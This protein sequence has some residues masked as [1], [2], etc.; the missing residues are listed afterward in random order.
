MFFSK[1][2]TEAVLEFETYLEVASEVDLR[3]WSSDSKI[4]EFLVIQ[5]EE[6]IKHMF[7]SLSRLGFGQK[8]AAPKTD[9]RFEIQEVKE[10]EAGLFEIQYKYKGTL[11]VQQYAHEEVPQEVSFVL[12]NDPAQIYGRGLVGDSNPCT[13]PHYQSERDFWYFWNPNQFSCPLIEGEDFHQVIGKIRRKQNTVATYPEYNRMMQNGVLPGFIIFG[14][15]HQDEIRDPYEASFSDPGEYLNAVN[16]VSLSDWMVEEGFLKE[17]ISFSQTLIGQDLPEY[18][19]LVTLEVFEKETP[20]GLLRFFLFYGP[21]GVNESQSPLFHVMFLTGLRHASFVIYN[22]HSGLG[23]NLNL[24]YFDQIYQ[25][26]QPAIDQYQ[27]YYFNSCSSYPYYNEM[28]F[29]RKST[30]KDPFG[31]KNLDI[32]TNGLST[33]FSVIDDTSKMFVKFI[34][35]WAMGEQILS[36]QQFAMV[37]D[38]GNLLGIN[39]DDDN[40]SDPKEVE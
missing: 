17:K 24:D 37:A 13:D 2:A 3:E 10:A 38:S 9:H 5:I 18:D 23:G 15:N 39:G 30:E 36:F 32:I 14:M 35:R 21:S 19:A 8:K 26:A 1:E 22:G 20:K 29:R 4:H 28:Y 34:D 16:Y 31:T 27:I 11:L 40:P 7:G 6:Q 33:Y 25:N 12:P